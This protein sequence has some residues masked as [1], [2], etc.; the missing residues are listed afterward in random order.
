MKVYKE[1]AKLRT[2][3]SILYGETGFFINETVFAYSR[4]KKGNPG[5]LVAVNFDKE[6]NV[7]NDV[8]GM[9]LMPST[10]TVQIRDTS[11][12]RTE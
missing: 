2:S 1:L 6:K 8:T 9:A 12:T 10:G 4:V 11:N 7:T 5:Y 3:D